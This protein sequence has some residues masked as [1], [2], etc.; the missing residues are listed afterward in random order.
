MKELPSS[1]PSGSDYVAPTSQAS[2]GGPIRPQIVPVF[3]PHPYGLPQR[4]GVPV[5]T[6]YLPRTLVPASLP[7]LPAPSIFGP[8]A[9]ATFVA[10]MT[11][12][13]TL[14][15]TPPSGQ[16]ATPPTT[17]PAFRPVVPTPSQSSSFGSRS[18]T[19]SSA[20]SYS[21]RQSIFSS[22][23]SMP[24]SMTSISVPLS[25]GQLPVG[26]ASTPAPAQ[27][28]STA[29]AQSPFPPEAVQFDTVRRVLPRGTGE[30]KVTYAKRLH[31]LSQAGDPRATV[32]GQRLSVE[33]LAQISGTHASTLR[34][35]PALHTVPPALLA[36]R[37]TFGRRGGTPIE[38]GIDYAQRLY[39][40]S[41]DNVPGTR[42]GAG[43][44]TLPEIA[45]VTGV[46]LTDLNRVPAFRFF[47][48]ELDRVRGNWAPLPRE[49]KISHARRIWQASQSNDA[50]AQVVRGRPL[51]YD[52][53]AL[54]C[55][56]S[57]PKLRREPTLRH[58]PAH[59]HPV[60][61]AVHRPIGERPTS[62]ARRLHALNQLGDART[63]VGQ[64]ALTLR[65]ISDLSGVPERTLRDDPSMFNVP[66]MLVP[67]LAS[68]PRLINE[69]N[70]DYAL[71]MHF[72][73]GHNDTAVSINGNPLTEQQIVLLS[74][75]DAAVLRAR[76]GS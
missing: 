20:T 70:L 7:P 46:R 41:Q 8:Q 14:F 37:L 9:S 33:Q 39:R 13:P 18:S 55:G 17:G 4:M 26:A 52:Q 5:T 6:A 75:V 30:P 2:S 16:G 54:L 12:A 47:P 61:A 10:P 40:A 1:L 71:R 56:I 57:A 53:L 43:P 69:Q 25:I 63:R 38:S 76:L 21:S 65:D 59:L 64:R 35:E 29:S 28:A 66:P 72:A 11:L 62:Y 34:N 67:I 51:S 49:S 48:P 22:Q 50:T 36:I 31:G 74:G 42:T 32:N 58:L 60:R 23:G 45:L 19:S 44:L 15:G 27:V 3:V 68:F 73:V 24:P